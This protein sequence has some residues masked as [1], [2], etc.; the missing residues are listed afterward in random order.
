MGELTL[1]RYELIIAKYS[2]FFPNVIVHT[3]KRLYLLYVQTYEDK[4]MHPS[5][6]LEEMQKVQKRH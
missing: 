4:K 2:I 3:K 6:F 5:R 1:R